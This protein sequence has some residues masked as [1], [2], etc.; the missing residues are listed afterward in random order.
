M[1]RMS[2]EHLRM[3]EGQIIDLD[4]EFVKRINSLGLERL[5]NLLQTIPGLGHDSAVSFSPRLG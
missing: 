4:E 2:F 3:L 1:I 5:L